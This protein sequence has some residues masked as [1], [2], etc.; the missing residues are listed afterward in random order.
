[1]DFSSIEFYTLAFV[2]A[3]AVLGFLMGKRDKGLAC[4]HIVQL[5]VSSADKPDEADSVSLTLQDDGSILLSRTGLRLGEGETINLVITI[6]GNQCLMVE[7]K[8]IK[9][10]RAARQP[11][12][13]SVELTC[14]PMNEPLRVRYES[15]LTTRWAMF[16]C[17]F[18]T[19][20][21]WHADL[22]Y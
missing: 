10:R 7:K 17:D 12:H 22:R 14:L 19:G 18:A 15:Q 3:M 13:A 6:T 20:G 21:P 2:V 4:T 1:M 5:S 16:T 9:Q 11:I 8:G